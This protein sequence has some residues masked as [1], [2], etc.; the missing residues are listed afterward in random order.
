MRKLLATPLLTVLF[1]TLFSWG[2]SAQNLSGMV[3]K[4]KEKDPVSWTSQVKKVSDN[5]YKL[6]FKAQADPHWHFYSQYSEGTMPMGFYFDDI[7]GYTLDGNASESPKPKEEYDEVLK[8]L[9]KYWD[10]TTP[11]I[12]IQ[13]IKITT[14]NKVNIHGSVE[15]QACINGACMP[16]VYNFTFN[17]DGAKN[18]STTTQAVEN[19]STT[20][21]QSATPAASETPK[22]VVKVPE[23]GVDTTANTQATDIETTTD[24]EETKI[25]EAEW[26]KLI[27][28]P[29]QE[30]LK[31]YGDENSIANKGFFIIFLLGFAGGLIALL[32]PCV[33]P[34]I[35]MT[36]S[37]F[38]KKDKVK[39]KRDAIIY[40]LSIIAIYMILG[41]GLTVF[42]GADAMNA[43][44]TSAIFN[45]IF[46]ILLVVF[47]ISFFGAFEIQLPTK[48]TN[49]MDQKA[50]TTTGLISIFFMAFTLVL[51][52][53]SCTG[54][55][56]GTILVEAVTKGIWGPAM[57]MLGFSIALALPF[58]LFAIFP[59]MMKSMPKSGGWLNSV[60]VVLAFI[61]LALA[62]KFLS[63]AD[64]AY[65]WHLLDREVFLVLWIII[66]ALLG[67][68]LLGKL[69]FSHDSKVEKVGVFKL[70]LAMISLSFA[71]YMVPGLWGAPLKAI[72]AF[73]P[74]ISTQ[75]FNLYTG[76]VEAQFDNYEEGMAY[77]K[78]NHKPV[79][80]DFTGWGCVNCRNMELAVWSDKEVK[81]LL[82]EKYVLISLYVDDKLKLPKDQQRISSFSGNRIRTIGNL[83]S[84]L[85]FGKFGQ[86]SQPYYFAIDYNGKPLTGPTAYELNVGNYI[87]FLNAGLKEFK[88]RY[89]KK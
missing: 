27:W 13:K 41:L 18:P 35:P 38:I 66:F 33:W 45:I 52:S 25:N 31:A 56:M 83:W 67:L 68:Y 85:Q 10:E 16:L 32:T 80:I 1:L 28:K 19:K 77:A 9:T 15:Y 54:P 89:P 22:A 74:P 40:G 30:E 86:S 57:G 50:D 65:H 21:N 46:F 12:F 76:T 61:E 44:A 8:G 82:E 71:L 55:I 69:S 7:V 48:W 26:K 24:S 88:I 79:V 5:E 37:F 62:F 36:V 23:T 29:I 20:N 14:T 39:G 17:L 47:A 11:A 73:S 34:M 2:L 59:S 49:K 75:D 87:K 53:F 81:R 4:E 42:A 51:V 43:L 84:D 78:K 63:V 64:M 3:K 72:S 58:T 70:F 6:I 60:K